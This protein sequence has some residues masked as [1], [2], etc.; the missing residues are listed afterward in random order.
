V[1]APTRLLDFTRSPFIAAYFAFEDARDQTGACAIWAIRESWCTTRAGDLVLDE[2]SWL[3]SELESRAGLEAQNYAFAA[4]WK[5]SRVYFDRVVMLRKTAMVLPFE[6]E[7][8]SERLSIQ[9][10]TFLCPGN[11]DRSFMENLAALGEPQG[12]EIMK[13]E[14][15]AAVRGRALEQLRLVNLSRAS[16]F[17]GLE[18]FA[19]SFRQLLVKEPEEARRLRLMISVLERLASP[20]MTLKALSGLG[21]RA[22]GTTPEERSDSG[23]DDRSGHDN[24]GEKR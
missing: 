15:P 6:P 1:C 2:H 20:A 24:S 7:P 5:A 17:P 14:A 9:Q 18:G 13:I 11:V 16:L 4:G 21:G 8:L 12:D 23:T 3:R 19:Q 22:E 10:G